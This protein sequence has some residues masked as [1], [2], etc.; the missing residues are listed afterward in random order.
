M[1]V[2]R[3]TFLFSVIV[4]LCFVFGR[5]E[6]GWV[7]PDSPKDVQMTKPLTP[8]DGR[9]YELVFSDEFE[10][11]GRTFKDGEDPRW[12]AINKNDYTNSAL[13]YYSDENVKTE[14]GVLN[15]TTELKENLYKAFDEKTKKF[16]ADTKHVQSAMVQGWNKF[17]V[18]GGIVE[19]SAKLPGKPT[20]GG[21]WPA[22]WLLGNLA[23]AT[24][25]GSSDYMW[26]YSY[27]KCS[28]K[29][30]MSQEI[31]ACS[32]INHYGMQAGRG[33]GAPEIDIL[34]AMQGDP[35]E[36]LPN[37]NVSRPYLSCS[38]QIAP[39]F[40]EDRPVL[41][42]LPHE[43]HWYTDLEYGNT[44]EAELNPFFYGV[45]LVHEPEVYTYQADALSANMH[46]DKSH[47]SDQHIYRIEWEPP[48]S[49]GTGGYIKWYNDNELVYGV[50]GDSLGLMETEIPS[51]PMYLLMNTAVSSHW[52]FPAPCPEGCSCECFECGNPKC[53]CGMPDGYCENFPASFEIDYVRVWQAVNDS[54][55][56]LGC[57]TEERPSSL[58]IQGHAKR[59]MEGDQKRPLLPVATGGGPCYNDTACGSRKRGHCVNKEC[60]CNDGFTG[61]RCL[62]HYG[63][64]NFSEPTIALKLDWIYVPQSLKTIVA[65]LFATFVVSFC[66]IIR[67]TRNEAAYQKLAT[68]ADD[69]Y[70]IGSYSGGTYQNAVDYALPTDQKVVTYCV[71]DGRLVDP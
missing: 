58:F 63:F 12:T 21:L 30:R 69:N 20:T 40:K 11:Q 50:L 41:G 64:D 26:P 60:K 68:V 6:A 57:S 29:G 9:R 55:H 15:I 24:Y 1:K 54:K 36:K 71:I 7:D 28:E 59:Y 49:D 16:Y 4:A 8:G 17:C 39:G 32:K 19:F 42:S 31:N 66:Y 35:S 70:R 44:T 23:R 18:T 10:T 3:N 52:G 45:T 46:L 53:A 67:N 14:N 65:I 22:L 48:E 33:R 2:S 34:E 27:S 13:H 47:Y 37:T 38:L 51:E 5:V 25:V 43:D 61:P 62:S 56:M